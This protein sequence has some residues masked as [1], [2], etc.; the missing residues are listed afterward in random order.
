MFP[1]VVKTQTA[2]TAE[3]A[4]ERAE[5]LLGR[6]P[7]RVDTYFSK[8]QNVQ[9]F[10][11]T[12]L[13]KS[14]WNEATNTEIPEGEEI[15]IYGQA[16]DSNDMRQLWQ[17]H[18]L[19][20]EIQVG[21]TRYHLP[22]GFVK[23][24]GQ[25]SPCLRLS[26][27]WGGGAGGGGNTRL[28]LYCLSQRQ[29]FWVDYPGPRFDETGFPEVQVTS[30]NA[31]PAPIRQYL[32]SWG[33]QI[34][35]D[36]LPSNARTDPARRL[37]QLWID[38]NGKKPCPADWTTLSVAEWKSNHLDKLTPYTTR[39]LVNDPQIVLE[40]GRYQWLSYPGVNCHA[41]EGSKMAGVGQYDKQVHRYA[42]VYVPASAWYYSKKLVV[43]G[44]WVYIQDCDHWA[45]RFNKVTRGLE[46]G[47]FDG[48]VGD[49]STG[50][51]P[52]AASS[53]P[54]TARAFR[55]SP[56]RPNEQEPSQHQFFIP[57]GV[58]LSL[59]DRKSQRRDMARIVLA[60]PSLF[61]RLTPLQQA[62][63]VCEAADLNDADQNTCLYRAVLD[64]QKRQAADTDQSEG[65]FR[66]G[67]HPGVG[68]TR[69]LAHACDV[70][71]WEEGGHRSK[72]I[73][74]P[75]GTEVLITWV[76]GTGKIE[77]KIASGNYAGKLIL[78]MDYDLEPNRVKQ[79]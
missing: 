8:E 76:S 67:P 72:T 4:E 60:N 40:D 10:A 34:G 66:N 58:D 74:V 56:L 39:K 53:T 5:A 27:Y 49:L 1:I 52:A 17:V 36:V 16:G 65:R 26:A 43:V 42:L 18:Q 79:K 62:V 51:Y 37:Q 46:R 33:H 50:V 63:T 47:D 59:G 35:L 29:M 28:G 31:T 25:T 73:K 57:P 7:D 30:H 68:E 32:F 6:K 70:V 78:F 14:K 19:W 3:Q 69:R 55:S 54:A 44:E 71:T 12:S 21:V 45:A 22:D 48:L 11:F 64:A 23:V 2:L 41:D 75:E 15:W 61:D 9:Y 13:T 38:A 24:S 20:P 77:G